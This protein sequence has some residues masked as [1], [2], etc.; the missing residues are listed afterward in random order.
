MD[1]I[2]C[3]SDKFLENKYQC[4]LGGFSKSREQQRKISKM[5]NEYVVLSLTLSSE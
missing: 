2:F 4:K 1:G 3:D 5:E